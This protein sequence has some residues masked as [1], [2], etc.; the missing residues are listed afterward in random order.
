MKLPLIHLES[1]NSKSIDLIYG[2]KLSEF[3]SKGRRKIIWQT[4][5]HKKQKPS[6]KFNI[7]SCIKNSQIPAHC[8]QKQDRFQVDSEPLS[9]DIWVPRGLS[10]RLQIEDSPSERFRRTQKASVPGL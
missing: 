4:L 2:R 10:E 6:V 3:H 1:K 7:F 5:D 8:H 9:P